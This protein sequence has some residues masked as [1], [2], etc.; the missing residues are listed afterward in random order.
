MTHVLFSV[1]TNVLGALG[2]TF[3]NKSVLCPLNTCTKPS[4]FPRFWA[5]ALCSDGQSTAPWCFNPSAPIWYVV[6]T[7]ALGVSE[8]PEVGLTGCHRERNS[9]S[10]SVA[11]S[12]T[13][14]NSR[15]KAPS[16]PCLTVAATVDCTPSGAWMWRRARAVN[17]GCTW[18]ND[19]EQGEGLTTWKEPTQAN[20]VRIELE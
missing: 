1:K 20:G 5:H 19:S 14:I 8:P 6:R 12:E 15:G 16:S 17:L 11:L 2:I 10:N 18:G 4:S 13:F 9:L 3:R 7:A